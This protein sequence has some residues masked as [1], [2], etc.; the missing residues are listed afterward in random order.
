MT[1]SRARTSTLED[2][3]RAADIKGWTPARCRA[4]LAFRE[5]GGSYYARMSNETAEPF[6]G[7]IHWQPAD[8]LAENGLAIGNQSRMVLTPV[9]EAAQCLILRA[10]M[11][12]VP[13]SGGEPGHHFQPLSAASAAS[14]SAP[15]EDR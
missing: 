12:G 11:P 7:V 8:W 13:S 9:G 3:G 15:A 14:V 1:I 10:Q 4:I 5:S 6:G 2:I